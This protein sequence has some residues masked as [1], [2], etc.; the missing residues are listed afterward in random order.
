M[1]I[2]G[3]PISTA[4]TSMPLCRLMPR[5]ANFI[6]APEKKRVLIVQSP[7]ASQLFREVL[8]GRPNRQIKRSES[9]CAIATSGIE[10]ESGL[11]IAELI[12]AVAKR[13][14]RA[15]MMRIGLP[16]AKLRL[17]RNNVFIGKASIHFQR[18]STR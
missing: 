8:V 1:T 10:N 18:D 6:T 13:L 16:I 12:I 2:K 17:L 15:M 3:S 5:S 14:R 7:K 9:I 4:V 11:L